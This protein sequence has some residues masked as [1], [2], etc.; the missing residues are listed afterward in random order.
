MVASRQELAKLLIIA[1]TY[2]KTLREIRSVL[3]KI[4]FY[5]LPGF[6]SSA[7]FSPA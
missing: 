3:F 6:G 5:C 1:G 7:A 2:N 4:H